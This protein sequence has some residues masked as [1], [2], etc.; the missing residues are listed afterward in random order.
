MRSK[1]TDAWA[2]NHRSKRPTHPWLSRDRPRRRT[3]LRTVAAAQCH[4]WLQRL[5]EELTR[6]GVDRAGHVPLVRG[7]QSC[8]RRN[9][10]TAGQRLL[11]PLQVW[12]VKVWRPVRQEASKRSGD[13][14]PQ[15][16][17]SPAAYWPAWTGAAWK[18]RAGGG[19]PQGAARGL[20]HARSG[21]RALPVDAPQLQAA[22]CRHCLNYPEKAV[23]VALG[24]H[25]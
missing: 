10:A 18:R 25:P 24:C 22:I 17:A 15:L 9:W 12:H 19:T 5:P 1:A 6:L 13:C 7:H 3:D 2:Q 20:L 8:Q 11:I 21:G 14:Y 23:N 4:P 16:L